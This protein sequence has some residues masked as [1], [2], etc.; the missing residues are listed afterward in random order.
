MIKR[1]ILVLSIFISFQMFAQPHPDSLV[2]KSVT[3][4]DLEGL[5]LNIDV[6][7]VPLWTI[8]SKDQVIEKFGI[9]DRYYNEDGKYDD[10]WKERG[11]YYGE[12]YIE[13]CDGEL[14]EFNLGDDTFKVLTTYFD[15][16][17]TVGDHISV[18]KGFMDGILYQRDPARFGEYCYII[19]DSGDGYFCFR[20][21]P[22]GY[23]I[24]IWYTFP[25]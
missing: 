24:R 17:I 8:L 13:T 16:G 9:P 20:T 10:A 7:G 6:N 3:W 4:E 15:S 22:D 5:H 25:V 11:Y 14:W 2:Y 23:I 21:D 18:F 1:V 19:D 12:N